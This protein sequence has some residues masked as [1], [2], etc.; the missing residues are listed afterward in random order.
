LSHLADGDRATVVGLAC[1]GGIRRRLLALGVCPSA[2]VCVLGR[3]PAG[4]PL[5]IRAGT[6]RLMLRVHEAAAVEVERGGLTGRS[7][8]DV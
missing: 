5:A 3:A 6:V 8:G 7:S 1:A 2:E 4:G